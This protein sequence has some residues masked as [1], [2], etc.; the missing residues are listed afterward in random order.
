MRNFVIGCIVLF[1]IAVVSMSVL[2]QTGNRSTVHD[3]VPLKQASENQAEN[4]LADARQKGETRAK[5][6]FANGTLQIL[7]CGK[8][9]SAGNPLID[10]ESHLPVKVVAGCT[11]SQEFVAETD[12]YNAAMRQSAKEQQKQEHT[13]RKRSRSQ[14]DRGPARQGVQVESR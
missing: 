4:R 7:Y 10:D 14:A 3:V 2:A 6:D 12:A 11:V 8:P 5:A 1:V 9:W 13:S